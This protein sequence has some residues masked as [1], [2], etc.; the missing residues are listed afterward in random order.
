[1]ICFDSWPGWRDILGG[2]WV[3]GRSYHPAKGPV[4]V[5]M[6]R[7]APLASGLGDFTVD[8]EVY[9]HLDLSPGI[10]VLA[11]ADAG[12]GAQP[13]VWT[14][15]VGPGRVFYDG[16]GHD[17]ASIETPGHRALILRGLAW[18]LGRIGEGQSR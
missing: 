18:A 7:S 6:N 16:L 11:A 10:A 5:T 4:R 8:D 13:F 3:W 1:S 17:V 14:H 2:A 9:H 12:A 15:Q